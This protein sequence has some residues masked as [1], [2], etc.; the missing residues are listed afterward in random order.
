MMTAKHLLRAGR[1]P[2]RVSLSLVALPA[3]FLLLAACDDKGA[4]QA[5]APPPPPVTVAKPV[6][7]NIVEGDEITGRFDAVASVDVRARVGGY[8]ESVKFTDGSIVKEGD[9]LFVIDRRPYQAALAQAEAQ[10]ASILMTAFAFILGVVPLVTATGAGAEMRQALGTAVFAGMIGV[11]FFGL[12]LTPV[13]YVALR[14]LARG[15]EAA[16]PA[17]DAASGR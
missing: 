14:G 17:P 11:T 16:A 1:R 8:L 2:P 9:L 15:R 10:A 5:T 12:F 3:A 13:F 6:V 4:G 7:K